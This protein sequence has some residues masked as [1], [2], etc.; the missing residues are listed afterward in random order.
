MFLKEVDPQDHILIQVPKDVN[1]VFEFSF[2]DFHG[3][4][5]DALSFEFFAGRRA[6]IARPVEFLRPL[7]YRKYSSE[8]FAAHAANIGSRI[9]MSRHF[10]SIHVD[11]HVGSKRFL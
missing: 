1:L 7:S 4:S 3:N 11:R 8:S 6:H 9:I 2:V 5:I 10:V